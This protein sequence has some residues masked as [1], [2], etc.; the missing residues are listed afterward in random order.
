MNEEQIVLSLIAM[1]KREGIDLHQLLDEPLFNALPVQ[2]RIELIRMYAKE[3]HA[4]IH[5][6]VSSRDVKGFL[7]GL[8]P[9]AFGG[10]VAGYGAAKV[11]KET[12]KGGRMAPSALIGGAVAGASFGAG[13]RLFQAINENSNR[14][15]IKEYFGQAAQNPTDGNAIQAMGYYGLRNRSQKAEAEPFNKILDRID[16]MSEAHAKTVGENLALKYNAETVGR[17]LK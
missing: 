11:I 5:S 7:K 17:R 12:F 16:T 1:Y 6:G 10:A 13:V 9:S 4:G 14:R 15:R 8:L 2:R 3:I